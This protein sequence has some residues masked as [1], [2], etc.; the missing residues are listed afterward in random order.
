MRFGNMYGKVA[1]SIGDN[2]NEDQ[3]LRSALPLTIGQINHRF[4][5]KVIYS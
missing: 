3:F 1:D 5:T 4:L 2:W